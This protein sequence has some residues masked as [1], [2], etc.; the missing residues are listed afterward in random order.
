[1]LRP[2][3]RIVLV[4]A[5]TKTPLGM[6]DGQELA[7]LVGT[8]AIEGSLE[9]LER[10]RLVFRP[11]RTSA[12]ERAAKKRRRHRPGDDL[13]FARSRAGFELAERLLQNRRISF[14]KVLIEIAAGKGQRTARSKAC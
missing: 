3:D 2:V 9:R 10:Q 1:M 14:A 6:V 4:Y 7:T 5:A 13:I 12:R 8:L 11:G